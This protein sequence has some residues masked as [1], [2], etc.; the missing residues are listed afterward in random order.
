MDRSIIGN[1]LNVAKHSRRP[2]IAISRSKNQ[3]SHLQIIISIDIHHY[4]IQRLTLHEVNFVKN[5]CEHPVRGLRPIV[6]ES[7]CYAMLCYY[8]IPLWGK[9]P[10]PFEAALIPIWVKPIPIWAMRKN[11]TFFRFCGKFS[12]AAIYCIGFI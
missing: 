6:P 1:W 2:K 7:L 4:H 5:H 10:F 8:L 12:P 11:S 3:N 9:T